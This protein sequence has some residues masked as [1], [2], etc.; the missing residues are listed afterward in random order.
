M[1]VHGVDEARCVCVTAVIYDTSDC[2]REDVQGLELP[3]YNFVDELRDDHGEVHLA[4]LGRYALDT[5]DSVGLDLHGLVL[6]VLDE[7]GADALLQRLFELVGTLR[8]L[9]AEV[10]SS[11]VPDILIEIGTVLQHLCEGC[12]SFAVYSVSHCA[13]FI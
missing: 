8:N 11:S 9:V 5:L 3:A 1:R 10:K 2:Q 4:D 7:G 6:Q 12:L 13:L